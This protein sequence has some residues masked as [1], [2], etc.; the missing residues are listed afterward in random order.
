[1]EDKILTIEEI[2]A[3]LDTET[4]P[5]PVLYITTS[6]REGEENGYIMRQSRTNN[7]LNKNK[8]EDDYG[9]NLLPY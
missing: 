7:I 3:E 8:R 1:M 2:K 4:Y 6:P 5:F 9:H